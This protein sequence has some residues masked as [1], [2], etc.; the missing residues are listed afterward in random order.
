M[1]TRRAKLLL[2]GFLCSILIYLSCRKTDSP[3]EQTKK[4]LE[5]KFFNASNISPEVKTVMEAMMRQNQKKNF[6][7]SFISKAGYPRWDKAIVATPDEIKRGRSSSDGYIVYVPFVKDAD[8][9]VNSSLIIKV[10]ADTTYKMLY[11][12][13]YK[14]YGFDSTK[15]NSWN[16]RNVFQLFTTFE[17]SIFGRKRFLITDGRLLGGKKDSSC[18]AALCKINGN[19]LGSRNSSY[20]VEECT[21]WEIWMPCL[22]ARTTGDWPYCLFY[23]FDICT[24]YYYFDSHDREGGGGG[25][26]DPGSGGGGGGGWQPDP[27]TNLAP[28]P[29]DSLL[30]KYSIAINPKAAELMSTS[31]ANHDWEYTT[32][33]VVKDGVIYPKN[34]HT[35]RDSMGSYPVLTLAAGEILLGYLHTHPRANELDR[36]APSDGDIDALRRN[37]SQNFVSF[38]ECGNVR[39]ALVVEDPTKAAAFLRNNPYRKLNSGIMTSAL[40]QPDYY[41]NWQHATQVA[42]AGVLG[43]AASNGIGLYISNN[44]DKTSYTKLNP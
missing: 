43:S 25:G 21:T 31:L 19:K 4:E 29:I 11:A 37:L 27:G 34:D 23:A 7:A 35:D 26:P 33:I 41:S 10:D 38:I 16:A 30:K 17:Y 28:V 22:Q 15:Q 2:W 36:S 14:D 3:P 13:D 44:A 24:T 8:N 18:I 39:Y 40:S 1:S 5:Q 9:M 20:T 12:S 32:T 6:V 42:V